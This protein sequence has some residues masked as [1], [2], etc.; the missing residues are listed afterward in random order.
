MCR[1]LTFWASTDGADSLKTL[2][3]AFVKASKD[4]HHLREITSGRHTSHDDGWGYAVAGEWI[5]GT[6]YVIHYKTPKPVFEDLTGLYK[7]QNAV[8][9]SSFM[10]G[11]MHAR[12]AS[13]G[14]AK[15]IIDAHPFHATLPDGVELWLA[16]NG[17]VDTESPPSRLLPEVGE[18]RPDSLALTLYLSRISSFR[19]RDAL[20]IALTQ[21]LTRTALN[22]GILLIG[23]KETATLT[24]NYNVYEGRDEARANYYRMY[25]IREEG[26]IANASSTITENYGMDG[27]PLRNGE[28]VTL[29][30]KRINGEPTYEEIR[31]ALITT[32][33]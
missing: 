2:L 11:V 22:L 28:L 12:K 17:S 20:R 30:T 8:E 7:L 25:R 16:H 3:E 14:F 4:D 18:G 6:P 13:S 5:E 15:T 1:L 33:P 32:Q 10:T 29:K 19:L 26:L 27:E 9:R 24:L 31:E 21:G 23:P